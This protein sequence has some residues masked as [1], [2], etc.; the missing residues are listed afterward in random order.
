MDYD[1]QRGTRHC[2]VSQRELKPG[3]VFYSVLRSSGSQIV[4]EDFSGEVWQGPPADTVGWWKS[5]VPTSDA[6]KFHW[7]PNDVMLQLFEDLEN[8]PEQSDLRYVLTL[9]LIR[10]RV[11]RLEDTEPAEPAGETMV[12][13]CP[14]KETDYR[15]RVVTPDEVRI[16]EIQQ[17]LA[18]LLFADAS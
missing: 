10:R 9:L 11:L 7:A 15:V 13:Y 1:I 17:E 3:E 8:E 16:Q 18:R 14:R 6:K 12:L 5:Q 2:A 4:R